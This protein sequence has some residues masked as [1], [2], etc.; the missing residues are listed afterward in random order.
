MI[1]PKILRV[2][3]LNSNNSKQIDSQEKHE[4]KNENINSCLFDILNKSKS[5]QFIIQYKI[6]VQ[7]E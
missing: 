5:R 6:L 7:I 3:I 1:T 4:I 2:E